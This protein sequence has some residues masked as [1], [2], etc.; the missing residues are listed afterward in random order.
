MSDVKKRGRVPYVSLLA[1]ALAVVLLLLLAVQ[2]VRTLTAAPDDEKLYVHVLDVGQSDAILLRCGGKTMLIDTGTAQEQEALRAALL[3]YRVK[4]IDVLVLTHLH[5]DHIGNARYLLAH[6]AIGRVLLPQAVGDEPAAM[7]F[8]EE[9]ARTE[10]ECV[11]ASTDL[12]FSLGEANFELLYAPCAGAELNGFD[13]NNESIVL[14][15]EFGER[16]FLFMG[17][18][19][20]AL[21]QKLLATKAALLPCDWLKVG[22][23][24]SQASASEAFLVVA[25]PRFAAISCGKNNSYG[26]P[27]SNT[28]A[29][30]RAAGATVYRTDTSGTLSFVCDG[31]DITLLEEG[32]IAYE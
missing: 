24:G 20:E 11:T 2:M 10:T 23:H 4:R 31:T 25:A 5:E 17:D 6:Y 12:C 3:Y 15:A 18:G 28:V 22:H 9:L 26:F 21:E 13:A 8:L 30:L 7:L 14:R 1:G 16:S 32:G 19:E 27:H 29:R